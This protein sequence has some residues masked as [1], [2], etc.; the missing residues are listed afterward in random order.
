MM[1][2]TYRQLG[3]EAVWIIDMRNMGPVIKNTFR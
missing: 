3:P 1:F 2:K